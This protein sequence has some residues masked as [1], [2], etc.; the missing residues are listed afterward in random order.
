MLLST[1]SS[2]LTTIQPD[3]ARKLDGIIAKV[4]N[5][6]G[7]RDDMKQDLLLDHDNGTDGEQ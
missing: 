5:N 7:L 6:I 4:A 3:G 1:L 2:M